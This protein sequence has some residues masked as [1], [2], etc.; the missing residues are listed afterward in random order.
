MPFQRLC[1]VRAD[2]GHLLGHCCLLT[3]EREVEDVEILTQI[4]LL[5]EL[6]VRA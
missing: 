1:H 5:T 2:G 6:Q 4:I 3:P